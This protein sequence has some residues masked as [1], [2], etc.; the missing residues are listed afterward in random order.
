MDVSSI[1]NKFIVYGGT[2]VN[3]FND[4]RSVDSTDFEWKIL[5]ENTESHAFPARFA[6]TAAQFD[7]YVVIFGGCG[8]YLRKLKRRNCFQDVIMFDIE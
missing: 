2:A 8:P 6:H 5:K 7:K 4:I 3:V 1:G